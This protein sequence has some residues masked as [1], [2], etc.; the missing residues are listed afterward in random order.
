MLLQYIDKVSCATHSMDE[1]L[2]VTGACSIG[3]FTCCRVV[4]CIRGVLQKWPII[5]WWSVLVGAG[6]R[7]QAMLG[8]VI[9]VNLLTIM[10]LAFT[11]TPTHTP[12]TSLSFGFVSFLLKSLITRTHVVFFGLP[13]TGPTD[14]MVVRSSP[15]GSALSV[16]PLILPRG[17]AGIVRFLLAA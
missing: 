4:C 6:V 16:R 14:P 17:P 9:G 1:M 11:S 5:F 13:Y 12:V 2:T 15:F 3:T 10:V 7:R 8:S